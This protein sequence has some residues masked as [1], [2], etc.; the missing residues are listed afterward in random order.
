M[1]WGGH[2]YADLALPFGL[3]SSPAI[4]ERYASLA[5][6]LARRNGAPN[7]IHYVDDFLIGGAPAPSPECDQAVAALL[8]LFERLGIPI[9]WAKHKLEGNPSTLIKFLGILIDTEQMVARLDPERIKD[10]L[11]AL[12]SWASRTQ[13]TARELQT[14]IGVLSFAAKVVPAGRTFLRRMLAT[15]SGAHNKKGYVPARNPSPV[16]SP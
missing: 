8:R 10:I 15:L 9:N 6:W 14:L 4:W 3:K 12:E 11:T 2:F 1:R 7:S 5:I 16:P 13:C